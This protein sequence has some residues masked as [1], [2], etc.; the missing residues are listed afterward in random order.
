MKNKKRKSVCDKR[1]MEPLRSESGDINKKAGGCLTSMA[2]SMNPG[3]PQFLPLG[4]CLK[5]PV[6]NLELV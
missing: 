2:L 5:S 4:C 1:R 6:F 3:L